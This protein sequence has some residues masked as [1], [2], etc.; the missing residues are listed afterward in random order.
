[1]V[2]AI[3]PVIALISL[4]F[5]SQA[6]SSINSSQSFGG[7]ALDCRAVHTDI[8]YDDP[9]SLMPSN[10]FYS[11][12]RNGNYLVGIKTATGTPGMLYVDSESI[13]PYIDG[14]W[15]YVAP[16]LTEVA[17]CLNGASKVEVPI[18]PAESDAFRMNNLKPQKT[19][20]D[21]PASPVL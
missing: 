17:E 6:I 15:K 21:I 8:T 18:T 12:D 3:I 13:Q 14:G 7:T 19:T 16:V 4:I 1:M 11:D 10:G 2:Y 20:T 5:G 9:T